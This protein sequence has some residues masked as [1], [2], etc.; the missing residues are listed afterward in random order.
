MKKRRRLLA[1]AMCAAMAGLM[2]LGGCSTQRTFADPEPSL[3]SN[4]GKPAKLTIAIEVTETEALASKRGVFSRVLDEIIAKYR[5]D[6]P[7]TEIELVEDVK[8][9]NILAGGAGAPDI[10]LFVG[11]DPYSKDLYPRNTDW[12]MDLTPYIDAWNDEGTVSNPASRIMRLKGGSKTYAIPCSYEQIMLYYRWDWLDEYNLSCGDDN[13][14]KASVNGW[15]G[16]LQ[17]EEKMGDKGRLAISRD[18]KPYLFDAMLWSWVGYKNISDLSAGYYYMTSEGHGTIFSLDT[19]VDAVKA[20]QEVLD[21]DID[22]ADP[23]QAFIDGEA[24]LY[25]GTGGDIVEL[26]GAVPGTVGEDWY[27]VGLSRGNSGRVAPLLDWTAWGV[28][29]DTTEPEKAVHFLWYLTN[30]DNSAHM[31]MELK[32]YGVKPIYR[33]IESYEPSLLEGGWYGEVALLNTPSY[34][35]ASPPLMFGEQVGVQNPVFS[36]LLGKLESGDVTPEDMLKQLDGEYMRL[37][38]EYLARGNKLPWAVEDTED[39]S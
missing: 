14:R 31:Y 5:A 11:D 3:L 22:A 12:L 39:N 8:G 15:S 1:G 7:N 23:I 34:R 27:A 19:A 38:E 16:L 37:L 9:E 13:D 29:K 6:F 21:K 24:G 17:V 20:Y 18:V 4:D 26:E 2:A 36:D 35:Y 33:E 32:D 30:A 25:L 10:E 28:N